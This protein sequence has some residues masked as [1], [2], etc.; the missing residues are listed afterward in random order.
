[1]QWYVGII[2]AILGVLLYVLYDRGYL[3]AKS[4]SAVHFIAIQTLTV[5]L[6]NITTF[7]STRSRREFLSATVVRLMLTH[8]QSTLQE[9]VTLHLQTRLTT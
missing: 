1:M 3:P 7:L 9:T 6:I 4:M 5:L 2:L 8:L